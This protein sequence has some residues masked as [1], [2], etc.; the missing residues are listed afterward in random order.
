[1]IWFDDKSLCTL[2]PAAA[3]LVTYSEV[4]EGGKSIPM[5]LLLAA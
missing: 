4:S 3:L 2:Q 5:M 1:M